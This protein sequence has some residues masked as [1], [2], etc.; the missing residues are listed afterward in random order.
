MEL[1]KVKKVSFM[2]RCTPDERK[3]ITSRAEAYNLTDSDYMRMLIIKDVEESKKN[4]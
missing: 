4:S 3:L 2:L 1:K